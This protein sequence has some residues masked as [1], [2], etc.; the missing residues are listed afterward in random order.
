M[1]Q[2][3]HLPA[4]R[5]HRTPLRSLSALCVALATLSQVHAQQQESSPIP[6]FSRYSEAQRWVHSNDPADPVGAGTL[7]GLKPA[8]NTPC[9]GNWVVVLSNAPQSLEQRTSSGGTSIAKVLINAAAPSLIESVGAFSS[10][11]Q[12][13]ATQSSSGYATLTATY[14]GPSHCVGTQGGSY[15]ARIRQ[16]TELKSSDVYSYQG[17]SLT[18]SVQ[19]VCRGGG[20]RRSVLP[21]STSQGLTST[22]SG[23]NVTIGSGTASFTIPLVGAGSQIQVEQSGSTLQ[24]DGGPATWYVLKVHV[25]GTGS[26]SAD[27]HLLSPAD[28]VG[29]TRAIVYSLAT[30]GDEEGGC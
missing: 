12:V 8:I 27:G 13:I 3:V 30:L 19:S 24:H 18:L 26:V 5:N 28:L 2:A 17:V 16:A 25:E 21:F 22:A 15:M 29:D 6:H 7:E 1:Q 4:L 11:P 20:Y 9:G 23:Q 10:G 14:V